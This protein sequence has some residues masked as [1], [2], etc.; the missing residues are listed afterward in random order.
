MPPA[1]SAP[2][3]SDTPPAELTGL[4]ELLVVADKRSFTAA[5]AVLRVTPSAISQTISAL[6]RRTGVRLLQR[7][8]RSVGLT[9]AGARLLAQLRPALDGVAAAFA[10]LDELRAR[11]SG[12]LRLTVPRI[13]CRAILDP[14]L[15]PFLA[16]HPELS[17]DLSV[18]DGF[19]DLVEGGFD[20]GIRLGESVG[21]DAIAL[22]LTPALRA[23]VV[24]SPAYFA[25]HPRPRHPRDLARHDCI[26]YRQIARRAIYR[27]EFVDGD[28]ELTIAVRGRV[29]TNDADTMIRAALDGLGLAHLIETTIAEPLAQG[30]LVRV[31]TSY[32]PQFPGLHLYYPSRRQVPAKLRALVDY[33]Q[34]QR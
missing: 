2:S 20:A 24:G 34:A 28:R 33:L 9:E 19:V 5:A 1:P 25:G 6:E 7:T 30:R 4:R 29:I 18:D 3:A 27:W 22:R 12:T 10:S 23:V 26:A 15:A 11:P 17:L 32:C 8:T 16:A 31:L 21:R 13:A 14:L